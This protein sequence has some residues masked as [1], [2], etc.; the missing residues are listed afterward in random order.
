MLS[1]L[2]DTPPLD[3]R[4]IETLAQ[5][6]ARWFDTVWLHAW[7]NHEARLHRAFA[8]AGDRAY[9]AYLSLLLRPLLRQFSQ[10][11]L[12]T[13]PLLPGSLL[14]SREW[15]NGA[16]TEQQRWFWCAVGLLDHDM[17]LGTLVTVLHHDHTRF[18]LPRA[19][20][21]FGLAATGLQNV[22]KELGR[23]SP[24]FACAVPLRAMA[25]PTA[26]SSLEESR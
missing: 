4:S 21:I 6:C 10:A 19:P 26:S 5:S 20:E 8:N 15:G 9:G 12:V 14:D 11:G 17:P 13:Y 7:E 2:A 25:V 1:H 23:R 18:R 16:Q 3:A 22:E 24:D